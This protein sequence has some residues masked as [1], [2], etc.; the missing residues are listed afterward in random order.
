[1]ALG[2]LVALT[3]TDGIAGKTDG[4]NKYP[5]YYAARRAL[6]RGSCDVGVGHLEVYLRNHSYIQKKYPDHY[7]TIKFAM[8][9]CKGAIEVRGIEDESGGID[10][11]PDHPPMVD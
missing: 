4:A 2:V 10:P 5:N 9:Q 6:E 3:M 8:Y 7:R 11:L 1:M